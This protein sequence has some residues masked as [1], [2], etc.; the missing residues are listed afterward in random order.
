MGVVVQKTLDR[1]TDFMIVGGEMYT[2][3]NGQPLA[4]PVQPSD[5]PVYK[6]AVAEGVQLVQLKDLR[7]YFRY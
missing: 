1:N 4:T 5:L 6:D 7:Q 2:D 3:D